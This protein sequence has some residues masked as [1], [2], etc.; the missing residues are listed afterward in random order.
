MPELNFH[1]HITVIE[2]CEIARTGLLTLLSN[3]QQ[4]CYACITLNEAI[5]NAQLLNAQAVLIGPSHEP[6]LALKLA[7]DIAKMADTVVGLMPKIVVFSHYANDALFQSDAAY[8]GVS[9]C[10]LVPLLSRLSMLQTIQDVVKGKIVLNPLPRLAVKHP[11][12]LSTRELEVLRLMTDYR[13]NKEIA[14]IQHVSVTTVDKQVRSIFIKLNVSNRGDA[15]RRA[16]Q[17]GGV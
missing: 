11:Q 6:S 8:S 10:I 1:L 4:R 17:L 13:S 15:I 16:K 9:A 12:L 7:R 14:T 3:D 5:T 2:P